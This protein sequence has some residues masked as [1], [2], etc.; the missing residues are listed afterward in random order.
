VPETPPQGPEG[1][2]AAKQ[3]PQ[4]V[5]FW[6]D[7]WNN[8]YHP[9]TLAA[10]EKV[11]T[12]AGFRVQIP[13][14]HICC[15][16]PLYDFGLLGAARATW[17][18]SSTAWLRR[19]MPDSPSS[20]SSQ[21]AP[22]SSRMR[23]WNFFP[24]DPARAAHEPAGLAAGRLAGRQSSRVGHRPA[25]GRAGHP[26]RPLP[27]QSRLRRPGQ[28]DRPAAKAGAA[29][30][31]INSSCCGMAGP[32]GFEADKIEVS[33]AIA[34][35]GLLPAV[36]SAA[37]MTIIVADGFSCREQINQL[38]RGELRGVRGAPEITQSGW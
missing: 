36:N 27:P 3:L 13:K 8:Y 30:E 16:R 9:Q 14:G 19:S 15:G 4:V 25:S 31:L 20:F 6:P 10:A 32:F 38:P 1:Q 23:R 12:Q 18:R 22:A 11:L 26:P 33:K 21:V 37:P 29:V 24:N 17:P 34:N 28:R 35:L 5:V 2:L 7:T